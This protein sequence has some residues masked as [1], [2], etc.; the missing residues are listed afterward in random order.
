MHLIVLFEYSLYFHLGIKFKLN[1]VCWGFTWGQGLNTY[2]LGVGMLAYIVEVEDNLGVAGYHWLT[3]I[4]LV[5]VTLWRPR[6]FLRQGN[7]VP[8]R[9]VGIEFGLSQGDFHWE[10]LAFETVFECYMIYLSEVQSFINGEIK[11]TSDEL[12]CGLLHIF[13]F[14]MLFII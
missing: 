3:V 11:R 8:I 14:E 5:E 7:T 13:M 1:C 2:V 12:I 4:L 6:I 9:F 10:I